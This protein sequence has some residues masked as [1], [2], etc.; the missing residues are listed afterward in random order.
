MEFDYKT[1]LG[2]IASIMTIWAH[3]PYLRDTI[4]GTNKPHIFTWV[5]WALLTFIAFAAQ[6]KGNAGP[7]A[8]VTGITGLICVVITVAALRNGKKDI[9]KSD[10]IIFLCGLSAIPVWMATSNPLYAVIIVTLIDVSAVIPT[11]RKAWVKPH[12]ENVF[13]YGFNVPRHACSIAAIQSFSLLTALYP[14]ALLFMNLAMYV[15]L[16]TRRNAIS[17]ISQPQ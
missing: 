7:G 6:I 12:E 16:K 8:W 9:T 14:A 4:R 17:G 3:I 1:F 5:I 11:F 10:W 15:M 2:I 13:M